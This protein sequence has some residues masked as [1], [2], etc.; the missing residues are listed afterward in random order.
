MTVHI[1]CYK[2]SILQLGL[3]FLCNYSNVYL[4]SEVFENKWVTLRTHSPTPV[5]CVGVPYDMFLSVHNVTDHWIL[6][7]L[8]L[9]G[10][11]LIGQEHGKNV[12]FA[13]VH[14]PSKKVLMDPNNCKEAKVKERYLFTKFC[15]LI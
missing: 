5:V 12:Q 3:S 4:L 2:R 1:D 14:L 15:V 10:I 6:C 11:K 7:G 9:D 8:E 13:L